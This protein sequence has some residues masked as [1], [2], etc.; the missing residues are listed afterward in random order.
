VLQAVNGSGINIDGVYT[1]VTATVTNAFGA[2]IKG[3]V[4]GAATSALGDGDGI[5]VDGL[6]NITNS[7]DVLALGNLSVDGGG[8]EGISVGGGTIIN[9]ATGRIIGSTLLADAPN[10]D[11]TREG[12]GILVDDSNGGSALAATT[13]T[14]SGLIQGKTG[15]GIKLIGTWNDTVTNNA[16]G[17]IQGGKTAAASTY[18]PVIDTGAGNDTV[19]NSGSIISDGGNSATAVSLGAGDDH[20]TFSGAAPTVTGGLDGGSG[21]ETV[22]DILTVNLTGGSTLTLGG[23]ITNF[24]SIQV[25]SGSLTLGGQLTLALNGSTAGTPT[26][27]G[28]LVFSATTGALVLDPGAS[29]NLILGFTPSFGETFDI[30]NF[31]SGGTL[32]GT[33]VGLAEGAVFTVGGQEFS[34]SYLGGVSGHD[35]VL[36]AIPEPSTTIL[37]FAGLAGGVA[38]VLRRRRAVQA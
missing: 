16:G 8:A 6:V 29:L 19:T 20:L 38:L 4:L 22:G 13:I 3:G 28:Q 30:I 31:T 25:Q 7:G 23:A 5:D 27:F 37:L 11:V 24:E 18:A 10:G 12:H 34:I 36:T 14:N 17:T 21:G 15:Y 32:S 33:F 35:V 9:N 2:T 26:G 1:T